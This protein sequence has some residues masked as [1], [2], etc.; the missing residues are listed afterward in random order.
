MATAPQQRVRELGP[1]VVLSGGPLGRRWY[2]AR[3]WQQLLD[4]CNYAKSRGQRVAEDVLRYRKTDQVRVHPAE[5]QYPNLT[6]T[7][8]RWRG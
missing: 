2:T 6:G 7:V 5:K 3:D 1:C 4:A 8:W